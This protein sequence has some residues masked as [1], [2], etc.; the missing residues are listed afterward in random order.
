MCVNLSDHRL[1]EKL[2]DLMTLQNI[3]DPSV[4]NCLRCYGLLGTIHVTV[5]CVHHAQL[6]LNPKTCPYAPVYPFAVFN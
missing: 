2:K 6:S 4:Q 5:Q 1:C 3:A